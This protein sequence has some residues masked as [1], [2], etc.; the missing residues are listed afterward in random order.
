[1]DESY[2]KQAQVKTYILT[3]RINYLREKT[4]LLV[5]TFWKI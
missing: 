4:S 3:K 2:E 1:M 5:F